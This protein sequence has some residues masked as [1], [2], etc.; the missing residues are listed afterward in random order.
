MMCPL[1]SLIL[2]STGFG[3][4]A[5]SMRRHHQDVFGQPPARIRKLML[6]T[7]GWLLLGASIWPLIASDGVSVGTTFWFGIITLAA[8][9]VAMSLTYGLGAIRALSPR[10]RRDDTH[11]HHERSNH[12][13]KRHAAVRIAA[14][15]SGER[16]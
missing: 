3:A 10:S 14:M 7:V 2:S 16:K 4:I 11:P 6:A 5:L 8:L 12:E 15:S 13:T 9:I 1:L